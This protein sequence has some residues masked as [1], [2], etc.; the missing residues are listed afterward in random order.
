MVAGPADTGAVAAE[1]AVAELSAA[2]LDAYGARL[3]EFVVR[4]VCGGEPG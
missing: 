2:E 4:R 3:E 1:A